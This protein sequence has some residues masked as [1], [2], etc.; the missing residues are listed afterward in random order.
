MIE[1]WAAVIEPGAEQV[2]LLRHLVVNANP[3]ADNK[4]LRLSYYTT[5]P[6]HGDDLMKM[7]KSFWVPIYDRLLE[8][9]VIGAYG[10]VEQAVHS[11]SSFTHLSWFEVNSLADLDEVDKAVAEASAE[12][13]EGD[14]VARKLAFM[15][16]V[17]PD[18]HYCRLIRVWK[19]GG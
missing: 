3:E 12:V 10:M 9:G 6:G 15:K 14:G 1:D 2:Q 18:G 4:Y 5:T 17:E 16:M 8:A 7:Y 19:H 11:D 13:S